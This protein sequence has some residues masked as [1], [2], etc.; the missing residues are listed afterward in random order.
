MGAAAIAA[1][2]RENVGKVII[3]KEGVIDLILVALA[4]EGHILLED[5]PGTGKTMLAKTVSRSL[6]LE[7]RR[8]QFTPDLLPS[9]VT[10]VSVFN[11]A[12]AQFEFRKGPAFTNVLLADEI[13][14]ATPRTQAALLE[15][16]EERQVTTDGE[17]RPLA[18]PFIVLATQ[19]PIEQEGT[20]PLPEAQLDRFLLRLSLGYPSPQE[21]AHL[22]TRFAA[23]NPLHA[24]QPVAGAV[25]V[26]A[27]RT[28]AQ[29]V[30]LGEAVS[31]YI[32]AIVRATREH[33]ALRLGAS[34]RATIALMR[35]ARARAALLGRAFVMPD[36]V[37]E[38][39][40]PVLSHR[41]I[42]KNQFRLRGQSQ[43]SVLDS[44][45]GQIPVPVLP[46]TDQ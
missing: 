25:D 33:E 22:L 20:F 31:A 26:V 17:T 1:R 30:L 23:T 28:A 46:D 14:R 10:G 45:L 5:V 15:C 27:M 34:P 37:K 19:N 6:Q 38:L 2:L 43:E 11:E 32:V 13:N 42:L 24:L 39:V 41:L 9:D 29:A 18:D 21:E 35:A 3:G 12:T 36:D 44:V 8:V 4:C 7:F 40:K 16:M